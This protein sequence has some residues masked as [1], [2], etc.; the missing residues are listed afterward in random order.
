MI[1][2]AVGFGMHHSI[3]LPVQYKP[4]LNGCEPSAIDY[5]ERRTASKRRQKERNDEYDNNHMHN[6][7]AFHEHITIESYS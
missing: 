7:W 4:M 1:L 5:W 6:M 3:D 2:P